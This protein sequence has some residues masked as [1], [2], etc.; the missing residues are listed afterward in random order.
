MKTILM[1]LLLVASTA[2]AFADCYYNGQR[3]AE[4]TQVGPYTCIAGKWVVRD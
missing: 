2:P 4:G 1:A 3:Y